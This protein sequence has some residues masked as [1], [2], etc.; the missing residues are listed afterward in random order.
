MIDGI[1]WQ[2]YIQH[3]SRLKA[4]ISVLKFEALILGLRWFTRNTENLRK[5]VLIMSD[6]TEVKG[7]FKKDSNAKRRFN[8]LC[9]RVVSIALPGNLELVLRFTRSKHNPADGPSIF[10]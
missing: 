3:R 5:R 1:K 8:L 7:P 10:K 9:Q 6:S 4:K 2:T